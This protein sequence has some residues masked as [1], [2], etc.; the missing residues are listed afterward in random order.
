MDLLQV[1][2]K[3]YALGNLFL[4]DDTQDSDATNTHDKIAK[5]KVALTSKT[6]PAFNKA[7]EYVKAGGK[8]E[9]IKSKY[10]LSKEIE[11][12]TKNPI[13]DKE[14]VLKKLEID[15]HYYGEF[16]KKFLSNSDIINF[17]NKLLWL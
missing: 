12:E 16:G 17:T 8:L 6:D 2:E 10:A 7:K 1:T 11:A 14:K 4:I 15:E 3:K 13:M 5:T 9:T